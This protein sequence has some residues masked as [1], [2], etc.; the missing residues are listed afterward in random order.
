M[1][2][3]WK[4]APALLVLA[5]VAGWVTAPAHA[6]LEPAQ[7]VED[8]WAGAGGSYVAPPADSPAGAAA[9]VACGLFVRVS[10]SPGGPF[11]GAIAGAVAA[12][13][14]MVLDALFFDPPPA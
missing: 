5:C 14:F 3:M 9:A 6:A 11:T 13:A 4:L 7:V 8:E 2:R 10:A 12:C 1:N